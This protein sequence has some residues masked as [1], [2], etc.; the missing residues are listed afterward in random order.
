MEKDMDSL[1][2]I[3]MDYLIDRLCSE[4][5][6]EAYYDMCVYLGSYKTEDFERNA[7]PSFEHYRNTAGLIKQ[8]LREN[9]QNLE[10]GMSSLKKSQEAMQ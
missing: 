5:M 7:F 3:Y 10:I 4:E 2:D 8:T 9:Y 1:Y 6:N